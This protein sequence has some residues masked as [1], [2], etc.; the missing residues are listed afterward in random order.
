MAQMLTQQLENQK[1]RVALVHMP[2][3]RLQPQRS[4]GAHATDAE[5][6]FLPNARRFVAPVQTVGDYAIDRR[7][8]GAVGVQQMNVNAPNMGDPQPREYIPTRD[9]N[10]YSDPVSFGPA[11]RLDG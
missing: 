2:H 4:E 10:F 11:G 8:L 3:R 1:R 5:N 6:H 7:I 9:A